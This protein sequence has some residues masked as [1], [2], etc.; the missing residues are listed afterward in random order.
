MTVGQDAGPPADEQTRQVRDLVD[1]PRNKVEVP[2]GKVPRRAIKEV[3]AAPRGYPLYVRNHSRDGPFVA[4]VDGCGPSLSTSILIPVKIQTRPFHRL[5]QEA[6]TLSGQANRG[7]AFHCRFPNG[8]RSFCVEVDPMT[9]C[10]PERI[11]GV[12]RSRRESLRRS[13]SHIY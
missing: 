5:L 4:A 1:L 2:K 12:Y 13:S 8:V 10:R 7:S 9:I 11:R 3:N 6:S